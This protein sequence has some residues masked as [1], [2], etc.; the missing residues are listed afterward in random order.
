MQTRSLALHNVAAAK[1]TR[2]ARA[3]V[4]TAMHHPRMAT[5]VPIL[6]Q[7]RSAGSHYSFLV[8]ITRLHFL[9]NIT[10]EVDIQPGLSLK[11]R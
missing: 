1:G 11:L 6:S 10:R 3:I 5:E 2:F 7:N 8:F 4:V 9:L